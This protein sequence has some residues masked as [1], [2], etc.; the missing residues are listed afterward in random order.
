MNLGNIEYRAERFE[1]AFEMYEK[2]LLAVDSGA[3]SLKSDIYY[4]MG[5]ALRRLERYAEAANWMEK[6]DKGDFRVNYFLADAYKE[7]EKYDLAMQRMRRAVQLEP[8]S[9]RALGALGNFYYALSDREE[10]E[11]RFDAAAKAIEQSIGLYRRA[12]AAGGTLY[13][14]WLQAAEARVKDLERLKAAA[15][16]GHIQRGGDGD[17]ADDPGVPPEIPLE[18]MEGHFSP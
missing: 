17:T 3:R 10:Q 2:A 6:A 8:E 4:S 18:A 7:L 1:A 12:I 9:S 14:D 5:M 16:Q 11:M 13:Q 15:K